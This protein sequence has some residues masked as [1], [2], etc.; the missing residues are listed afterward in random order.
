MQ[1]VIP[2]FITLLI[3]MFVTFTLINAPVKIIHPDALRFM[4]IFQVNFDGVSA[5]KEAPMAFIN[6]VSDANN[7]DLH[8]GRI[9][10]Y[11]SFGLEALSRK[12]FPFPFVSF[13]IM[14]I[15]MINANLLARLVTKDSISANYKPTI[16]S[17]VVAI[18]IFNPLFIAGYEMQ[19]L[20]A[21]FLCVTF[22]LLFM[23]IKKNELK[24]LALL[25]AMFSDEI[26]LVFA[27]MAV[28]I[29]FLNKKFKH[30]ETS[31]FTTRSVLAV[32][33]FGLLATL[34]VLISYFVILGII[35]GQLPHI[36]AHGVI[37]R[38]PLHL[39]ISKSTNYLLSLSV[40]SLGKVGTLLILSSLI[41][42]L[43][44]KSI[45]IKKSETSL[46]S[47][48]FRSLGNYFIQKIIAAS[49]LA[50]FIVFVMY[51]GETSIFYYGYP[52]YMLF[53]FAI[54]MLLISF[55]NPRF[56]I[57]L[58]FVLALLL[59]VRL[60][61]DLSMLREEAES[62]W[63]TDKGVTLDSFKEVENI[64]KKVRSGV[65]I[66][67]FNKIKNGQDN[68]VNGMD[69]SYSKKYFPIKGIVK[70][71]AWPNLVKGC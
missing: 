66:E 56:I 33:S 19:F 1:R 18:L 51:K 20:H 14:A 44:N 36:I 11:V 39:I 35:F 65:C 40:I 63:I 37:E 45:L 9:T 60:P 62:V 58:F 71:L 21:K 27:M 46:I 41:F 5:F 70:V 22:M 54:L 12:L 7:Y 42:V 49:F 43:F 48:K 55:E 10:N 32:I 68:N 17:L 38:A 4:G 53:M 25:G 28:F 31:N 6:A 64:I 3:V 13:L 23:L 61:E 24:T 8:R 52:V 2:V 26:G 34:G 29:V 69:Y 50:F 67:N 59:A 30:I 57:S 47:I 15:L 16:Y